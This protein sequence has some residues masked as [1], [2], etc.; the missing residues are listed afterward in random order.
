MLKIRINGHRCTWPVVI[1]SLTFQR[2]LIDRGSDSNSLDKDGSIPLHLTSRYRHVDVARLLL[3]RGSDVNALEVDKWTP[4]HL[5]SYDGHLDIAKL[6]VGRGANMDSQ[7]DNGGTPLKYAAWSG[8]LDNA[9]FVAESGGAVSAQDNRGWTPFHTAS[10]F[11]HL[12]E[13][14]PRRE[15]PTRVWGRGRHSEQKR[16]DGVVLSIQHWQTRRRSFPNREWRRYIC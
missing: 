16:R 4:L 1:G 13:S 15:V 7:N 8:Y 11:G 5:A 9:R 3:E 14:G 2:F 10:E 12:H 6:L